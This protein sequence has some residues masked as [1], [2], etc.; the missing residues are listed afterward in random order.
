MDRDNDIELLKALLKRET[1]PKFQAAL[2]RALAAL[3]RKR[4]PQ[5]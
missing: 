4:R 2:R 3:T 1:T 5:R